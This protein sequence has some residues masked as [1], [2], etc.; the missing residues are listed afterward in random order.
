MHAQATEGRLASDLE[1]GSQGPRA[2]GLRARGEGGEV[3]LL[4]RAW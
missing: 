2:T 4:E 1:G 3:E